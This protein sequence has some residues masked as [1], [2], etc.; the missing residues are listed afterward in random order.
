MFDTPMLWTRVKNVIQA[1]N[2]RF[3]IFDIEQDIITDR[4]L[5]QVRKNSVREST[6]LLFDPESFK[7]IYQDM[8]I[9]N[10]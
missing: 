3:T 5:K 6:D 10:Y 9:E 1:T 2:Q 4:A 8:K 7:D